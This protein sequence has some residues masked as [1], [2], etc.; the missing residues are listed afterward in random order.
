MITPAKVGN[1][2]N[3]VKM[4]SNVKISDPPDSYETVVWEYFGYEADRGSKIKI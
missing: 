2:L 3:S 1:E 4:A